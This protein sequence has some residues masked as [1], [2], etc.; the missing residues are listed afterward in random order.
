[1]SQFDDRMAKLKLRF[2]TRLEAEQSLLEQALA[3]GD[4]AE[5][6]RLAHGLSGSAGIFGHPDSGTA[7][8]DLE[9][10]ADGGE[11]LQE[12][13]EALLKLM[14]LALSSGTGES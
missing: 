11:P 3:S 14:S 12:A 9:A 8:H 5:L 1:M 10:A 7:A 2:A 13:A 4:R 6:K